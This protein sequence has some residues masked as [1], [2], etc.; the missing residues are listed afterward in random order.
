MKGFTK[1][2]KIALTVIT[3]FLGV[4][5]LS[6]SFHRMNQPSDLLFYLGLLGVVKMFVVVPAA[7]WLIWNPGRWMPRLRQ[8]FR[9]Q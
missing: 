2:L 5:I 7:I 8:A 1:R 3:L 4:G 9:R 6:W